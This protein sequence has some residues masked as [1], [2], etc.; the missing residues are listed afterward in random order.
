MLSVLRVCFSNLLGEASCLAW[1]GGWGHLA[2][3]T[4]PREGEL[5]GSAS[6]PSSQAP[7]V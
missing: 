4:A 3:P 2:L 7:L 1:G 5:P 6:H